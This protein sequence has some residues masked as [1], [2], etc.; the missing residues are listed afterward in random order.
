MRSEEMRLDGNAAGGMLRELFARDVTAAAATCAG[1]GT[2]WSVGAL[3]VY[4]HAMGTV[5][6][7]PGCDAVMLRLARTPGWLRADV[8][9]IALLAVPD[10]PPS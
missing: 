10:A 9:G 6:R 1:C 7:C 2:A 4:G 3:L 5:M 8:S